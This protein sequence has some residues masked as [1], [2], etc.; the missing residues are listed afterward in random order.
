MDISLKKLITFGVIAEMLILLAAYVFHP[1]VEDTFRYAA[2]Y[3][4][5]F[6]FLVF[7]YTFY[8]FAATYPK[9]FAEDSP[10][11]NYLTLFAVVHLIHWGFLA[12]SVYLNAIPLETIKVIG[13]AL[14]YLMIVL[15]P[16]M[17]HRIQPNLQF[18]YFYYVSLVMAL[19][20]VARIKGD[21][22]GADPS[23]VHYLGLIAMV[24]ACILFGVWIVRPRSKRLGQ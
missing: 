17:L 22:A 14:A 16:F 20:F 5:R 4:G 7:V 11:R 2:R 18:V 24:G 9:P 15:A 1:E 19:T 12:M 13:G 6:S 23:W 3:S 8:L 10:L 21:F